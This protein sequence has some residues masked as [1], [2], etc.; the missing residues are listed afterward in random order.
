MKLGFDQFST[1]LDKS[2]PRIP[3]SFRKSRP[4]TASQG[5][6]LCRKWSYTDPLLMRFSKKSVTEGRKTL[7]F[8][9]NFNFVER[10]GKF[11]LKNL[12]FIL[13]RLRWVSLGS[14]VLDPRILGSQNS[15][16]PESWHPK[17]LGSQNCPWCPCGPTRQ[18]L[19][20]VTFQGNWW[21]GTK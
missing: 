10:I 16:I 14:C 15:G 7:T 8:L 2:G 17:I 21:E 4:H 12:F 18:W 5:K 9:S 20:G 3:N 6:V 11:F 1:F 13:I 19:G